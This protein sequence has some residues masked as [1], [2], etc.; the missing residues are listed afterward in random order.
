MRKLIDNIN[1]HKAIVFCVDHYNPL[2]LIRSLGEAGIFPVAILV[3][4][5]PVLINKCKYVSK[6]HTVESIEE[7]YCV[8]LN[9]YRGE[10]SK[11]LIFTASDDIEEYLDERY[12]EVYEDFLF[13]DGGKAGQI[14]YFMDKH[15]IMI[16]AREAGL[17]VPAAEVLNHGELPKNLPY[18][19]ITKSIASTVG[20]WKNDVYICKNDKELLE[21]YDKILSPLVLVEEYFDKEN[22]L[23]IDGICFDGGNKVYMPLK[24][25]YIRFSNKSYGNYMTMSLFSDSELHEKIRKLLQITGFNGVFSIEFLVTKE[26]KLKFLEI[27]F[28]NSTWS[29]ASTY[30]G[31]NLPYI[32]ARHKVGT[33]V[34]TNSLVLN[35]NPF[36]A[37]A[38]FPDFSENVLSRKISFMKW[39]KDFRNCE[40]PYVFNK[41]DNA[42]FYSLL[43][44]LIANKIL[45]KI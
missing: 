44:H 18:P 20:G 5:A 36:T 32:W 10:T 34:D 8:L 33:P 43:K 40:C 26:K 24:C 29:Y 35:D 14:K 16:A 27:N 21:A 3:S 37:M 13:F 30:A 4:Q 2:G 17:E 15:N 9:N 41:K 38:E 22:E 39:L 42:P 6:L 7:G 19:V 1:G 45:K 23:C 11:P 31:A 28:R 25:N 12:D